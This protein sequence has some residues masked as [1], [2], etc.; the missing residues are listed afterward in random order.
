MLILHRAKH[1]EDLADSLRGYHMLYTLSDTDPAIRKRI[2]N[3][4]SGA[5]SFQSRR[6]NLRKILAP[7]RLF[8]FLGVALERLDDT[9]N[10]GIIGEISTE[11]TRNRTQSGAAFPRQIFQTRF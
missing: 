9:S 7:F 5:E 2:H 1:E 11:L 10:L 8:P 6:R 4:A 3:A